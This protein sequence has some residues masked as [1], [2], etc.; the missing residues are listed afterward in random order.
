MQLVD[1]MHVFNL[2]SI[3]MRKIEDHSSGGC[4]NSRGGRQSAEDYAFAG[5]AGDAI[6]WCIVHCAGWSDCSIVQ[7][8]VELYKN[9]VT[10]CVVLKVVRKVYACMMK[11]RVDF[12]NESIY[13]PL[14]FLF[15]DTLINRFS[16]KLCVF[17][18]Q[19][20]RDNY[21]ST[22]FLSR[23]Y[24]RLVCLLSTGTI[25]LNRA[26]RDAA[27]IVVSRDLIILS[28]A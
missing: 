25:K 28:L 7:A 27:R 19:L 17:W 21:M 24:M 1:Y 18:R 20:I 11:K 3:W 13:I 26:Y 6:D 16:S 15:A 5:N 22:K 4:W 8:K 2:I 9:V 10:K 12:T 14:M 23:W